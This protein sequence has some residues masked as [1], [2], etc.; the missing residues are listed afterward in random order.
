MR[1]FALALILVFALAAPAKAQFDPLAPAEIPDT[2]YYEGEILVGGTVESQPVVRGLSRFTAGSFP[3]IGR[4]IPDPDP[5][6]VRWWIKH[7]NA[8]YQ[9]NGITQCVDNDEYDVLYRCAYRGAVYDRT[10]NLSFLQNTF[11]FPVDSLKKYWDH[12]VEN[13]VQLL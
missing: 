7:G 13:L 11:D 4:L 9:L 10:L 8:E 3:E 2:V 12:F 1:Y 6:G 5:Y